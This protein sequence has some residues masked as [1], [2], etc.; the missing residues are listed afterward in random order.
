MK[1][2]LERTVKLPAVEHAGAGVD[3]TLVGRAMSDGNNP[4]VVIDEYRANALLTKELEA[5]LFIMAMDADEVYAHRW[6]PE[7]RRL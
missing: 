2:P 4:V 5:D 1:T 3:L 6:C 7:A